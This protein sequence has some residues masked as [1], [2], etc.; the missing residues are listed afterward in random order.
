MP[1]HNA[2]IE[3]G[4]SV[5]PELSQ[6]LAEATQ[7]LEAG[8]VP[9]DV[10]SGGHDDQV[11]LGLLAAGRLHALGRELLDLVGRQ[12][13]VLFQKSLETKHLLVLRFQI[14]LLLNLAGKKSSDGRIRLHPKG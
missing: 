8:K 10:E 5:G 9:V 1:Y 12:V 3:R 4:G 14:I 11:H 7:D 13:N 2:A 6:R